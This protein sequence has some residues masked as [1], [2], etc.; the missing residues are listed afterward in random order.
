MPSK[1]EIAAYLANSWVE[2]SEV[3]SHTIHPDL[4]TLVGAFCTKVKWLNSWS[5]ADPGS[6]NETVINRLRG[7]IQKA[8]WDEHARYWLEQ[9]EDPSISGLN[10][11]LRNMTARVLG[12]R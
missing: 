8:Y 7:H 6:D 9:K 12:R 4:L 5:I 1:A 3:K 2:V 10:D 11:E